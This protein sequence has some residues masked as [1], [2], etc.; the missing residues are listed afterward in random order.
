MARTIRVSSLVSGPTA[1]VSVTGCVAILYTIAPTP[2]KARVQAITM[3]Q[4]WPA[5]SLSGLLERPGTERSVM[6]RPM[7]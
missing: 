6:V 5:S 2:T 3:G 4:M 7:A 1:M